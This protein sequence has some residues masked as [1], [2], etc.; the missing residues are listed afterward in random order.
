MLRFEWQIDWVESRDKQRVVCLGCRLLATIQ[1]SYVTVVSRA[2]I[3][4]TV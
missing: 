4:A 3:L 1:I 2:S